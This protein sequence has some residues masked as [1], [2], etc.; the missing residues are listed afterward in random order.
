MAKEK[1]V[2][3]NG[4]LLRY[5]G[6]NATVEIPDS[7]AT[8]SENAFCDNS[9]LVRVVIPDGVSH[10]GTGAFARCPHLETVRFP[11]T[12]RSIGR[13]AFLDCAALT[14][15]DLPEALRTLDDFAFYGCTSLRTVELQEG[16]RR[17]GT[18]CFAKCV[19]LTD[20]RLPDSLETMGDA[21]AL[22]SALRRVRLPDTLREIPR[23]CFYL[24]ESLT[25]LILPKRVTSLAV[26]GA[27]FY[28]C[29][30][31]PQPVKDALTALNPDSFCRDKYF[32]YTLGLLE[33]MFDVEEKDEE[34][35]DFWAQ[36][37]TEGEEGSADGLEETT[38][39]AADGGKRADGLADE[40]EPAADAAKDEMPGRPP[41]DKFNREYWE[42]GYGTDVPPQKENYTD[43]EVEEYFPETEV[44]NEADWIERFGLIGEAPEKMSEKISEPADSSEAGGD[45]APRFAAGGT[46]TRKP[47]FPRQTVKRKADIGDC[48]QD[49]EKILLSADCKKKLFMKPARKNGRVLVLADALLCAVMLGLV[50]G[51]IQ[52]GDPV[53][54]VYLLTILFF[55]TPVWFWLYGVARRSSAFK[56]LSCA[57]TDRRMLVKRGELLEWA[58]LRDVSRVRADAQEG[59]TPH[60]AEFWMKNDTVFTV[61]F[62][63]DARVL[64][65]AANRFLDGLPQDESG[66]ARRSATAQARQTDGLQ[67][68]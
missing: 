58:D 21:F 48:L 44:F 47:Q 54:A 50:I 46:Q 31:L 38:A 23:G 66:Q 39:G 60:R 25:D 3:R 4:V 14:Q 43:A 68:D 10:I 27:G 33:S 16:L 32:E 37:P 42:I 18:S 55:L 20:V 52:S 64:A 40:Q 34:E 67:S 17:I 35:F 7:V 30:N 57:L 45:G 28:G 61:D 5:K 36:T 41:R 19:S 53:I 11:R 29:E 9:A 59:E 12:L 1:F 56:S 13:D 63:A 8:I 49:G 24:C 26:G 2:V 62:L 65:D 15:V 6:Q 22:C 51:G